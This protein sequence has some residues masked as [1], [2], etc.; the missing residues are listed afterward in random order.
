MGRKT[1]HADRADDRAG[2]VLDHAAARQRREPMIAKG[3]K[4]DFLALKT[5]EQ[6]GRVRLHERGAVGLSLRDGDGAQGRLV[7]PLE[8][9][10][11]AGRNADRLVVIGAVF[12][13]ANQTRSQARF[14]SRVLMQDSFAEAISSL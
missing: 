5:L 2:G 4:L 13:I 11:K 9:E 3:G 7:R 1:A 14:N 8:G 6:Q 12:S 10:K